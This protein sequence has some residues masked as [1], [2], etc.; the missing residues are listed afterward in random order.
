[1]GTFGKSFK[2][3]LELPF[4]KMTKKALKEFKKLMD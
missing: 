3:G 4:E 2:K 1:M